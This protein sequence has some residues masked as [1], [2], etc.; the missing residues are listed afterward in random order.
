M[1]TAIIID[2]EKHCIDTLTHM[3]HAH[4]KQSIHLLSSAQSVEDG[5]EIIHEYQPQ[6]VFLDIEINDKS[7]FD[8]LTQLPEIN[9]EIIFTTA[10]NKYAVEAFNFSAIHYLL[11]P[12]E[13]DKLK[14]AI[15]R[16][17]DKISMED[18]NKKIETLSFNL[19][20]NNTSKRI[21]IPAVKGYDFIQVSDIIRCKA[22]GG[23]SNIYVQKRKLPFN[24][25]KTLSYYDEMLNKYDFCRTHQSHLVNMHYVKSYNK[26]EDMVTL[27]DGS[28]VP[29]STRLREGFLKALRGDT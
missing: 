15:E 18:L 1:I 16:L 4:C 27:T 25:A 7:G 28:E 19:N 8:L 13:A 26:K 11:K 22:D 24:V 9:F 23:Y 2:D 29:V 10:Y 21:V 14:E 12:I 20:Q 3:I 6:L 5:A 17:K